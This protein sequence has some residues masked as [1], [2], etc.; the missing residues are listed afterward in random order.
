MADDLRIDE[1]QGDRPDER[2]PREW[3]P[4]DE[5][6]GREGT[7]N[8]PA[9]EA[10]SPFEAPS[11]AEHPSSLDGMEPELREVAEDL[12]TY[13]MGAQVESMKE[14]VQRLE[15]T[16]I[17][18]LERQAAAMRRIEGEV[19]R[20]FERAYRAPEQAKA[21]YDQVAVL[22][23]PEEASR[24]LEQSPGDYGDLWGSALLWG[25]RRGATEAVRA[26]EH[27]GVAY[28]RVL[29]AAARGGLGDEA[30]LETRTRRGPDAG[31]MPNGEGVARAGTDARAGRGAGTGRDDAAERTVEPSYD[32]KGAEART[33]AGVESAT[34]EKSDAFDRALERLYEDPSRARA[35]FDRVEA[36]LG[37]GR[38]ALGAATNPE[39][40]G[41]V[42]GAVAKSTALR[43]QYAR[44]AAGAAVELNRARERTR[45][46]NPDPYA[47]LEAAR[48]RVKQLR[49]QVADL[50]DR[51]GK[52]TVV[53]GRLHGMSVAEQ[54]RSI[55]GRL[56]GL[57]VGQL[58]RLERTWKARGVGARD[59]T[60]AR[61]ARIGGG[62]RLPGKAA[63]G[64]I[65]ANIAARAIGRFGEEVGGRETWGR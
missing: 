64:M 18:S 59:A 1:E 37:T 38:A 56:K 27:R 45:R 26:L 50:S 6:E 20:L 55:E 51:I 13:E 35:N 46:M 14:E 61:P 22:K 62:L 9:R 17:P 65:A 28:H 33:E 43:E 7:G 63:S 54:K 39:G 15:G 48:D 47:G 3:Q 19:E 41:T 2:Q 21:I 29:E 58:Q 16:V 32:P 4:R 36:R 34:L 42:R 44:A 53:N 8:E 57:N 23:G 12:E 60:G 11:P 30:L 5:R 24:R 25:Q 31:S 10:P 40:L 49:V 52:R